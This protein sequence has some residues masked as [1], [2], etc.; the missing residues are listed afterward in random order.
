MSSRVILYYG[1][2]FFFRYSTKQ[3][4]QSFKSV[5]N[6]FELNGVPDLP[7]SRYTGSDIRVRDDSMPVAHVAMAVE[8]P[9]YNHPDYLA[10]EI[11]SS[12]SCPR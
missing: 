5:K 7:G 10:M 8:G 11:A 2:N 3:V 1:Y 6:T 12:V 9:G 4:S